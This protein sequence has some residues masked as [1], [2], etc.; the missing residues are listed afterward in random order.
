MVLS[1]IYERNL[2]TTAVCTGIAAVVYSAD[3][4]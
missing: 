4:K 2:G 3:K 1:R